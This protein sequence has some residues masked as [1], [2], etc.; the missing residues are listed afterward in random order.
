MEGK[1][2]RVARFLDRSGAISW[3]LRGRAAVRAPFLTVL[4]YHRV[5]DL[6]GDEL[7]DPEVVDA[8]TAQFDAQMALVAEHF[9]VVSI[10]DLIA[11][12]R[13]ASLPANPC[14][15][16]FDDGYLDCHDNALPI[17]RR[18]GLSAVFFIATDYVE[19]RRVY[20]WDRIQYLVRRSSRSSIE[21]RYPKAEVISLDSIER[22]THRL[23]RIVK[24]TRGLAL[25][26]FLSELA[27]AADVAWSDDIETKMANELVMT[28]D[29]IRSMREQGMEIQ[30]HTRTHRVLHTVD[31]SE[32]EDE[33]YGSR[34]VLERELG[35]RVA[36]L[37]YPVGKPIKDRPALVEAVRAAGY[38]IGFSN[39]TGVARQGRSLDRFDVPRIGMDRGI[40]PHLF[41]GMMAIPWLS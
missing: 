1:R 7:F 4:T 37:A 12:S 24:D 18:H 2:D 32:L 6:S 31:E 19:E 5:A 10:D 15:I 3:I 35:E 27:T 13:G 9:Q 23:L 26:R 39:L 20:W 11:H 22:A 14:L 25:D 16:T 17:L 28:W 8:T 38:E 30:S 34:L 41:R 33:L 36:A 40:S 29:Q 21:L